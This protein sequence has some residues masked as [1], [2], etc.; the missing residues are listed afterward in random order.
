MSDFWSQVKKTDG[1]WEW[2]GPKFAFG[3]GKI[4]VDGKVHHAHRFIYQQLIGPIPP[5][6]PRLILCHRC[7]NPA[8]VR[9]DHLYLGTD[10]DNA[11][12]TE[13]RKRRKHGFPKKLNWEKVEQIRVE[14]K[15]GFVSQKELAEKFGVSQPTVQYIVRN[16]LWKIPAMETG[17]FADPLYWKILQ[18]RAKEIGWR[19][20]YQVVEWLR[21]RRRGWFAQQS[22]GSRGVDVFAARAVL[23]PPEFR[24]ITTALMIDVKSS[25]SQYRDLKVAPKDPQTEDESKRTGIPAVRAACL[26]G[27]KP[28][29]FWYLDGSEIPHAWF[30]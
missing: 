18:E 1:C 24:K 11:K 13:E 23:D 26:K 14:Y 19:G 3:Y 6:P 7:D 12:D 25:D 17:K 15:P 10:A 16:K 21:R 20:D 28:R 9:P 29:F 5:P 8:C 22:F 2:T 4:R 27:K 30:D